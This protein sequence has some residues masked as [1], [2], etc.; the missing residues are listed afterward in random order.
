M[1]FLLKEKDQWFIVN[2]YELRPNT[3]EVFVQEGEGIEGRAQINIHTP[4]NNRL[5]SWIQN[6]QSTLSTIAFYF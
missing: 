5:M 4:I 6:D 1:T 3:L 2:G